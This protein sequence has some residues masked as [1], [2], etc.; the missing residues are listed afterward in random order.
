L[1]EK[2]IVRKFIT[3]ALLLELISDQFAYRPTASTTAALISLT[4]AVAQKLESCNYIGLSCL[5]I[6]YAKAFDTIN[7]PIL[8]RKLMSLSIPPQIQRW[9][10][11]FFTGRQ[12]AVI[13][14]GQQ[15]KSLP[16][17]RSVVQGSGVGP[18]AHLVYSMDLKAP[19]SYNSILK[20]ADDTSIL[21]PQH[22]S[23]TVYRAR[24]AR[25]TVV[26]SPSRKNSKTFR[27]GPLRISFKLISKNERN[28][29]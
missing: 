27:H 17:T 2:L 19:S 6:D 9:I 4:H 15:S 5:Q 10:F 18:S 13:S 24:V 29:F 14:G 28:R 7:H 3:P 26:P 22:S 20:Y 12:Q 1:V 16:I 23:I 21:V 11:E 25:Y 8:F